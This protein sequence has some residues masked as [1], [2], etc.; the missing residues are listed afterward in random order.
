MVILR[1]LALIFCLS[2]LS[3]VSFGCG[4]Q[5]DRPEL[6]RVQGTVTLDG[7][8]LPGVI[9]RFFPDTGR[10]STAATDS[11]GH[12]D[13]VYTHG[14]HGAKVGPH[15]VSLAWPDDEPGTVPIPEKYGDN[16]QEKVEVKPGS[17]TFNF[18]LES[19]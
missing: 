19:K 17:N 1:R 5:G 3:L 15:T 9:V 4:S 11:Q 14:V 12:Y 7:R 18:A 2:A 10:P 8:P 16:S 13:L 6:G